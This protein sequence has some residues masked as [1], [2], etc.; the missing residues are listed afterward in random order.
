MIN[1]S[2]LISQ[3]LT[4]SAMVLTYMAHTYETVGYGLNPWIALPAATLCMVLPY[5]FD[6][7]L[8]D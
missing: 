5:I 2:T 6:H 8:T 1:L 4:T 7:Y 3:M